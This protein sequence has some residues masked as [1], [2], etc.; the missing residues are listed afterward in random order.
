MTVQFLKVRHP[1]I[2]KFTSLFSASLHPALVQG[3]GTGHKSGT[4]EASTMNL[5]TITNVITQHSK[6]DTI[7]C[8]QI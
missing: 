5:I 2:P 3:I 4:A 1:T 8:H 7:W 6:F